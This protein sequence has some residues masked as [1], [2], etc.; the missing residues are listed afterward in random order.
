MV[1]DFSKHGMLIETDDGVDDA[2]LGVPFVQASQDGT[3]ID[4][5]NAIQITDNG[6]KLGSNAGYVRVNNSRHHI[7]AVPPGTSGPFTATLNDKRIGTYRDPYGSG[8]QF[9][10][11]P[12][13]SP[14]YDWISKEA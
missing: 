5:T 2:T 1:I 14:D 12:Q 8:T 9:D 10:A 4:A 13:D 11:T 7:L 6:F 3:G